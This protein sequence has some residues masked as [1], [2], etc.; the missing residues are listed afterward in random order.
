MILILQPL[1]AITN[2]PEVYD[3]T[4]MKTVV[5]NVATDQRGRSCRLVQN[6]DEWHFRQQLLRYGS[7]LH[8]VI[9]TQEQ[10]DDYFRHGWLTLTDTPIRIHRIKLDLHDAIDWKDNRR[11]ALIECLD[12]WRDGPEIKYCTGHRCDCFLEC[13]GDEAAEQVRSKLQEMGLPFTTWGPQLA[14]LVSR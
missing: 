7:G 6:E 14:A 13:R 5:D 4:W 3:Y 1:Q 9:D 8:L 2:A 10:L 11:T 12:Q